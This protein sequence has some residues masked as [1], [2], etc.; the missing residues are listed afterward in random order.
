MLLINNTCDAALKRYH[1]AE[2][3]RDAEA[4]GYTGPIGWS[5]HYGKI[6]QV[7]ACCDMGK[8]HNWERYIASQRY[9]SLMRQYIWPHTAVL[10]P[11]LPL[12]PTATP[13]A[14]AAAAL[15]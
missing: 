9:C 3:C 2:A 4:L 11:V 5:P 14:S 15:R 8:A 10:P 12:T 13:Q 6:R 1:V 7:D